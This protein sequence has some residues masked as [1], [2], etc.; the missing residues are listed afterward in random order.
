ML[1][2]E[3]GEGGDG[4]IE[5]VGAI[6]LLEALEL[7]GARDAAGAL[8]GV[9]GGLVVGVDEVDQGTE[10]LVLGVVEEAALLEEKRQG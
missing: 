10:G 9:E 4:D 2:E 8:K 3:F 7:G 5:R 6:V 1:L